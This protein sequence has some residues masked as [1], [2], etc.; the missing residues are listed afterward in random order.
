M[1]QIKWIILGEPMSFRKG[2]CKHW[3]LKWDPSQKPQRPT[4]CYL[5]HGI[6]LFSAPSYLWRSCPSCKMQLP[7]ILA[8]VALVLGLQRGCEHGKK[9]K[10]STILSWCFPK[11]LILNIKAYL[12][13]KET[14]FSHSM[15]TRNVSMSFPSL[16]TKCVSWSLVWWYWSILTHRQNCLSRKNPSTPTAAIT[17]PP[18]H[19]PIFDKANNLSTSSFKNGIE[20]ITKR[21]NRTFYNPGSLW[22]VQDYACQPR[23]WDF[24]KGLRQGIHSA[25]FCW[26]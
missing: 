11:R 8:T 5:T 16:R 26:T 25:H 20:T 6:F 7:C 12:I 24:I 9:G 10:I 14:C 1:F 21:C 3:I 22:I 15:E 23:Q 19:L 2:C 13:Q 4:I 17:S 18:L